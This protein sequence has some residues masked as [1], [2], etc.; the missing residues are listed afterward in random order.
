MQVYESVYVNSTTVQPSFYNVIVVPSEN[1]ILV[2][3][4]TSF[5]F[6]A[7]LSLIIA[8]LLYELLLRLAYR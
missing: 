4:V 6:A 5:L 1:N 8:V 2:Y 3:Y 7:M